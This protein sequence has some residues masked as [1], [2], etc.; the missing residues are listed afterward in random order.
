MTAIIYAETAADWFDKERLTIKRSYAGPMLRRWCATT[1]TF[2]SLSLSLSLS[3]FPIIRD[4]TLNRRDRSVVR[5]IKHEQRQARLD[6]FKVVTVFES[7][8]LCI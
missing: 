5:G 2:L 8:T 3:S 1:R 6:D 7:L 4:S